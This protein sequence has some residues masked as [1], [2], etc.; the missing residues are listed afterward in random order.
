MMEGRPWGDEPAS[1]AKGLGHTAAVCGVS[2]TT[3]RRLVGK[4]RRTVTGLEHSRRPQRAGDDFLGA[5]PEQF[6]HADPVATCVSAD[7]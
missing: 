4:Y 6:R 2:A 3:S 7:S 1:T 5:R